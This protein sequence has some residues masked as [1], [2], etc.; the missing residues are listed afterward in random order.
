MCVRNP[1]R[2]DEWTKIENKEATPMN[3]DDDDDDDDAG[4]GRYACCTFCFLLLPC[5]SVSSWGEATHNPSTKIKKWENEAERSCV[6]C[7]RIV[8]KCF[9]L[10]AYPFYCHEDSRCILLFSAEAFRRSNSQDS[11]AAAAVAVQWGRGE[12]R[13]GE[14]AAP[15]SC[16]ARA[17]IPPA[18]PAGGRSSSSS[19]PTNTNRVALVVFSCFSPFQAPTARHSY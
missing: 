9:F 7:G 11:F 2:D 18:V 13:K 4:R 1:K 10:T 15:V 17:S 16:R 12:G 6:W 14:G 19:S 5:T 8:I 3:E